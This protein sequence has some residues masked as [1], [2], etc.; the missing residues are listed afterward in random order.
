M[1][2]CDVNPFLTF[3]KV[4]RLPL[5]FKWL[6]KKEIFSIPIIGWAMSTA[7]CINIDREGTRETMEAMNKAAHN[8]QEGMSVVIFPEKA[9]CAD[10]LSFPFSLVSLPLIPL[11][12]PF[13]EIAG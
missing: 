4:G 6:S 2:I 10:P 7:G 1:T 3:T 9:K 12:T 13:C 11:V 8:I 5:Q